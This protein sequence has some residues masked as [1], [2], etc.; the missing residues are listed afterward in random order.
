MKYLTVKFLFAAA[1]AVFFSSCTIVR[2]DASKARETSGI[3]S[4]F[5]F[6]SQNSTFDPKQYADQIWEPVVIP[7]I[8]SLSVEFHSLLTELTA[9][10][11]AA[12][13]TYGF[14]LLEEGNQFNFAVKG[15]VRILAIDTTSMN[16]TASLDFAPFD[17][18]E[19]SLMSIGPIFRGSTLRDIQNTLSLNDV[20]NQVEFARLGRELNNKVRDVVLQD[21]D[22]SQRIGT[23]AELLGAFTYGGKGSV[24]EIIPVQLSFSGEQE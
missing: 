16:G 7:R 8:E 18:K 3:D 12:S 9:D 2:N 4:A 10:E 13:R 6:S 5:A 23:E 20:G 14:R 19:D 11:A 22:F 24:I 1:L 15:T 17:G 21:M